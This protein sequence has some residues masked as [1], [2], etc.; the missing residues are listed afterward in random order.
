MNSRLHE[1]HEAQ[2]NTYTH[3][4]PINFKRIQQQNNTVVCA[5]YIFLMPIVITIKI[6][7]RK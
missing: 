7:I 6:N 5:V 2:F 3:L 1:Q 4:H